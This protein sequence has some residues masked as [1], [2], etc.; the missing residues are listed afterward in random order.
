M[1]DKSDS[2][3]LLGLYKLANR[4]NSPD[5]NGNDRNDTI[6]EESQGYGG[7]VS[8]SSRNTEILANRNDSLVL[9]NIERSESPSVNPIHLPRLFDE[10]STTQPSDQK[11]AHPSEPTII[12]EDK[13]DEPSPRETTPLRKFRRLITEQE[14]QQSSIRKSIPQNTRTLLPVPSADSTPIVNASSSLLTDSP[15]QLRKNSLSHE[16]VDVY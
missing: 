5:T 16:D 7:E 15:P 4:G 9:T 14:D 3:T 10:E 11:R 13:E 2:P 8:I 6:T 12:E 1:K